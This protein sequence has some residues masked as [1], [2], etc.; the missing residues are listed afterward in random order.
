M[1]ELKKYQMYID[2]EWC[3]AA[4]GQTLESV[5]PATGEIWATAAVAGEAEVNRA[6]G[7]SSGSGHFGPGLKIDVGIFAVEIVRA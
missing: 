2:G 7:M 4:D 5:N 1:S 6:V 3:D